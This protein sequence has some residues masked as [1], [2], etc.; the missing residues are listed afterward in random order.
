[1]LMGILETSKQGGSAMS[2]IV[3]MVALILLNVNNFRCKE[4]QL[5]VDENFE[6]LSDDVTLSGEGDG[7]IDDFKMQDNDDCTTIQSYGKQNMPG[8]Q[9]LDPHRCAVVEHVVSKSANSNAQNS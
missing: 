7:G 4:S 2:K 9:G 3:C 1:M 5:T 6:E 8:G